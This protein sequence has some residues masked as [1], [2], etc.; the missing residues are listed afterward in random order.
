MVKGRYMEGGA[1]ID[2]VLDIRKKVFEEEFGIS[3]AGKTVPGDEMALHAIAYDDDDKVVA[4]G[5][6][7]YDG[8][9]FTIDKIAVLPQNRKNY[10]GDFI[11]KILIDKA[12]SMSPSEIY[13]LCFSESTGFMESVGYITK[14]E[15][16]D[17]ICEMVLP[18][19]KFKGGCCSCKGH[20]AS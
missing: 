15:R 7:Y 2:C 16:K 13:G 17:G 14:S 20:A 19:D 11:L 6:L 4:A 8:I 3:G 18:E 1:N 12:A 10:Y 5:T 9:T